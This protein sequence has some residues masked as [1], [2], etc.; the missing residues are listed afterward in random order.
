MPQRELP[1][2]GGTYL[3]VMRASRRRWIEVG[4]LGRVQVAPGWYGYAGSAL[5]P[6]GL[7]ARA[8][9]HLGARRKPRWHIDALL[10]CAR[11]R[12]VWWQ[13]GS[14]RE[15]CRWARAM[16]ALPG[17]RL[18]WPGFGASDCRCQGHLC[19]FSTAPC[20]EA[21]ARLLWGPRGG[22]RDVHFTLPPPAAG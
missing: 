21:F 7:A 5:G 2:Q 11:V 12:E 22:V 15:E 18:I 9:R 4:S 16:A 8:G 19:W 6:G 17:A 13:A 20:R 1:R 14:R 10:A 3:L